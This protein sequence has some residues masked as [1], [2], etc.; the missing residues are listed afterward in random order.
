MAKSKKRDGHANRIKIRAEKNKSK[1]NSFTKEFK[2]KLD[3][4][5]AEELARQSRELKGKEIDG[6]EQRSVLDT[7]M[8]KSPIINTSPNR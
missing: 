1:Q 2:E 8:S 3:N 4:G 7:P 5:V 6:T